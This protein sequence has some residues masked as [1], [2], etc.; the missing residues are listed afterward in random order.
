MGW[1][2][3]PD[4]ERNPPAWELQAPDGRSVTCVKIG[5]HKAVLLGDVE[6]VDLRMGTC[7]FTVLARNALGDRK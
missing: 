7:R 1:R 2:I 3:D 6:L 4:N 5:G